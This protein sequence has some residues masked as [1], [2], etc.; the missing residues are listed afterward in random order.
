MSES[1]ERVTRGLELESVILNSNTFV[2]PAGI[3]IYGLVTDI[4]IFE[5]I[6]LPY[7]TGQVA[8]ID[9]ERLYDRIGFDGGDSVTIALKQTKSS[10]RIE[11]TFIIDRVI[12]TVKANET[13][14]LITF[15]M[16]E[17]IA[18][19]SRFI[20]VNR[21]YSGS[22]SNIIENI[23]KDY[24]QKDIINTGDVYQ[25]KLKVIVPNMQPL[26]AMCWIKNRMTTRDGIP[27][28]L[29]SVFDGPAL[30]LI[31][32]DDMLN[33]KPF[34]TKA[35]FIHGL[36]NLYTEIEGGVFRN[37]PIMKYEHKNV[38]DLFGLVEKGLISSTYSYYDSHS[39][40]PTKQF[41]NAEEPLSTLLPAKSDRRHNMPFNLEIDG[42]R[43]NEK[44][45]RKIY[46]L[47]QSGAYEDGTNRFRSYDQEPGKGHIQKAYNRSMKH[48]LLKETM[49]VRVSGAG[50]LDGTNHRSV[51][52]IVRLGFKSNKPNDAGLRFDLKKSGDYLIYACKHSIRAEKYDIEL[53]CVK[54]A[55]FKNDSFLR[56]G[57]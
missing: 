44:N 51:G 21:S 46:Q 4:E 5:H 27:Y 12:S 30:N 10:K 11:K 37:Y 23:S 3:N 25:N 47:S 15:H 6:D 35:P 22:P 34:N 54:N 29:F 32:L 13:T 1:Q 31:S 57:Q 50:F 9:T 45:A 43:I 38:D 19:I 49:R 55:S 28:Y 36:H 16:I 17:D 7:I 24:L 53:E 41:L 33:E 52:S 2:N 39:A 40:K 20:N 14:E 56:S 48:I 26:D 18:F 8:F 42:D